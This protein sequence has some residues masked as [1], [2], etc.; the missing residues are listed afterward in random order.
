M[1][2]F[3][4]SKSVWNGLSVFIFSHFGHWRIKIQRNYIHN[5]NYRVFILKKTDTVD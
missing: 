1:E 5:F 4:K 2:I 3:K